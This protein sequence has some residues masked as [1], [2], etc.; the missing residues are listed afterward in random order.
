MSVNGVLNLIISK[1]P[2]KLKGKAY[3]DA[4]AKALSPENIAKEG[5]AKKK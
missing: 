3:S 5:G 2:P 4:I 1:F